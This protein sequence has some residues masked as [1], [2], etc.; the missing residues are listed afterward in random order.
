MTEIYFQKFNGNPGIN[1]D[2]LVNL[3]LPAEIPNDYLE[4][5]KTYNGGEGFIGEEYVVLYKLNEL[6]QINKDYDVSNL[7]PDIFIFGSNGD[8]EALAF[9]F[10]KKQVKYVLIPFLFEY[11]AIIE[12]GDHLSGFFKRIYDEGYF[13]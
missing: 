2:E 3:H 12:L 8:S 7:V 11:D 10:R 13:V 5:C 6:M 4:F 9:D 1:N